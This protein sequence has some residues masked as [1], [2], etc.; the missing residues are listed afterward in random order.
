MQN[1]MIFNQIRLWYN[2]AVNTILRTIGGGV[3]A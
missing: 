2:K 1:G 3:H